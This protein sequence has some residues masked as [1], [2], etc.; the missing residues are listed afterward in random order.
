MKIFF[1][2]KLIL[3]L[4]ILLALILRVY[5]LDTIPASLNPD[6]AALG[7]TSFSFLR[8]LGDEHGKFL[9]LS[10]QS[11]GDWK[12]PVYSYIT[13][14][15]VAL[16]GLNEF[17]TRFVS[18][19][20]GVIGVLLIYFIGLLLFKKRGIAYLSSFFYA[21]SPWGIYFSRGAYEV[22]LA[23]TIF[24][25][26][27]LTFIKYILSDKKNEKILIFSSL[28]FGLTLFTQHNYIIFT[29]F[30]V[31]SLVIIFR[32]A[33]RKN[34]SSFITAGIFVFFIIASYFSITVG[35]SNKISTLVVFNDK[36]IIYERAEKLRGDN[37]NKNKFLERILHTK[38]LVGFYQIGQNYLNSFSPSFL[39]DKGGEK[40]VHN[41]GYFGNF[42][43]FDALLFFVG[44]SLLFWNR[45]KS[46]MVF[47]PWLFLAPIASAVTRD[48]PNSTRLFTIMPLFVLIASYGAYQILLFFKKRSIRSFVAKAALIFL[49]FLNVI[50]FIDAYFVH[51]NTQRIRFWRYGYREAVYLTQSYPG[52]NVVMRGPE[53]FPYIYFLFYEKYDPLKFRK[54]AVYYPPTSEGFYYVKSFGRYQFVDKIDY[55]NAAQNTIYIDDTRLDDKNHSIFLPSG[56]PILGYYAKEDKR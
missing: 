36:N 49:F 45:E 17:S 11:F 42:Y 37:A 15:P 12:L 41:L 56:E 23:T 38:Y 47:L 54:E 33:I 4:I 1:D 22:N 43:L 44:F 26:G 53:N 14:I 31:L 40:L 13:T 35:G 29:P 19:L 21:L 39:F 2:S 6:E 9:P 55:S 8:S 25:A 32:K 46:L 52:Y 28:L 16:F 51:L 3:L 5:K 50:Y 30:F 10:L 7:Y 20:S 24:L 27:L 34:K 18:A 48:S